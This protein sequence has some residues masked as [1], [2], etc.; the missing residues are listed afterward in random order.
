MSLALIHYLVLTL[1]KAKA[2]SQNGRSRNL[3]GGCAC[4]YGLE[5]GAPADRSHVMSCA[6]Y[7]HVPSQQAEQAG[8]FFQRR[9][10]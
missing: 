4:G 3:R 1:G 9:N 6:R 5:K 2:S 7:S 8:P 10:S